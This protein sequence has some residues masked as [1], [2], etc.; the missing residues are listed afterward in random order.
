MRDEEW[1]SWQVIF[2]HSPYSPEIAQFEE[3]PVLGDPEFDLLLAAETSE[4]EPITVSEPDATEAPDLALAIEK[5]PTEPEDT[6]IG[7]EP[8]S[9]R[10]ASPNSDSLATT[11]P[12]LT[13]RKFDA[14]RAT[15]KSVHVAP[16]LALARQIVASAGNRH[17]IRRIRMV[18]ISAPGNSRSRS[19]AE[20]RAHA[21]RVA[22]GEAID[23]MWPGLGSSLE[24]STSS[25][26]TGLPH[27][28]R[29]AKL[30][31]ERRAVEVFVEFDSLPHKL[32][33]PV[34][35]GG[36]G[37]SFTWRAN[38]PTIGDGKPEGADRP[39]SALRA[40]SSGGYFYVLSTELPPSRWICSLEILH[41]SN[42]G[43]LPHQSQTL[44][45]SATGL[46]IS[47][48]HVLTAAHC[49]WSRVRE[50]A[51]PD[52]ESANGFLEDAILE[53]KSAVVIPGRNAGVHPFGTIAVSEPRSF[54]SSARWRA[55]R[56]AN[57]ESD[58]ALITL[59]QPLSVGFWGQPP[60][61]IAPLP[62]EALNR[63][64]IYSAG[65]PNRF[66]SG[67]AREDVAQAPRVIAENAQWST[68]GTMTGLCSHLFTH[69]LPVLPGQDGAP[70]W[71][72]KGSER[73][74]AGLVSVGNQ[75]IRLTPR[76]LTRLRKWLVQDGVRPTF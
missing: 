17:A 48:R 40:L 53:A 21:V 45:L 25:R 38:Q 55:S 69:D 39:G 22:L 8:T 65:Y 35:A 63:A 5:P 61:R 37:N 75:A 1:F 26:P 27:G 32:L 71:L 15:L 16:L 49:V 46:L 60:F 18:G 56:G 33:F 30:P 47:P 70:I 23:R 7:S 13:L 36:A 52:R 42:D 66:S 12:A 14:N 72:Q 10:P 24:F 68:Q 20:N 59:E 31:G 29:A 58:L 2:F 6:E 3:F 67:A 4:A 64:A 51:N 57:I 44:T 28:A 74:L 50:S 41:H 62:D 11:R 76:V 54:R 19:L 73:I 34:I 43:H 9:K